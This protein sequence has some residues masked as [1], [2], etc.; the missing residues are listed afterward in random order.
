MSYFELRNRDTSK[1]IS[2]R[3]LWI[4]DSFKK[5]RLS[6]TEDEISNDDLYKYLINKY[7]QRVTRTGRYFNNINNKNFLMTVESFLNYFINSDLVL[8]GYCTLFRNQNSA[9]SI[10]SKALVYL[11]DIR[12]VY[13][14]EMVKYEQ[15]SREYD[16]YNLLQI[17]Y[18]ILVNAYY[19]NLGLDV[20]IFYNPFI[21]NSVTF[22][23]QDVITTAISTMESFLSNNNKFIDIEDIMEFVQNIKDEIYTI[24]ILDYVDHVITK[25]ELYDYILSIT[26]NKIDNNLLIKI[27]DNLTDV[28]RTKVYYKNNLIK[29]CQNKKTIDKYA[30]NV[31][32][33]DGYKTDD[34]VIKAINDIV[35]YNRILKDR[36]SRVITQTR[37]SVMVVDTDSNFLYLNPQ[38]ETVFDTLSLEKNNDNN[39]RILLLFIDITTEAL[40]RIFWSLTSS[41]GVPDDYKPIIR[42]KNEFVYSKLFTTKR[43]KQYAGWKLMQNGKMIRDDAPEEDKKD[44]KGLDIKKSTTTKHLREIFTNLLV[45]DIL[46]SKKISLK[47]IREKYDNIN[48]MIKQSILAGKTEFATP[49]TVKQAS[50]YTFPERIPAY[51]GVYLWNILEKENEIA[52]DEKIYLFKL[53]YIKDINDPLMVDLSQKNPDKYKL[54]VNALFNENNKFAIPFKKYLD[55]TVICAPKS[56]EVLPSYII[57][58]IDTSQMIRDNMRSGNPLLESLGI[59]CTTKTN[60]KTN[61]LKSSSIINF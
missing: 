25:D 42:M 48:D 14:K 41:M 11:L 54:L 8:T 57:P 52:P 10:V 31:L 45:D 46:R 22:S 43:K 59:F 50:D 27:I 9:T 28:E 39:M 3:Y 1:K 18:K 21:Q 15:G 61:V 37:K 17:T 38:V 51:R 24:D 6:M 20:S 35:L 47:E 40:K 49:K 53:K 30:N 55:K 44:I 60:Y 23:G 58:L 29:L 4:S 7:E 16:Y 34:S 19:G 56:I 13:K 12:S 2:Y 5:I 26:E 33:E 36:F 32:N